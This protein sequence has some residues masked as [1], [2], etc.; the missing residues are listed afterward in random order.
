MRKRTYKCSCFDNASTRGLRFTRLGGGFLNQKR[1]WMATYDE[2][3]T[4]TTC[5]SAKKCRQMA[6]ALVEIAE[7]I[8]AQ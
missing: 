3:N 6:K 8:E 2:D 5:L 7:E 1:L 4:I